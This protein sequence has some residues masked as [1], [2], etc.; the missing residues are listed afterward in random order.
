[1]GGSFVGNG[2]GATG[3]GIA[4]VEPEVA[5]VV[6]PDIAAEECAAD[7]AASPFAVVLGTVSIT[8]SVGSTAAA[9][10]WEPVCLV[11]LAAAVSPVAVGSASKPGVA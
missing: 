4:M 10:S 2:G 8:V 7:K 6:V 5:V 3:D 9:L 11:V 1:M